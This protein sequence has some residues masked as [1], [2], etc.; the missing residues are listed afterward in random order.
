MVAGTHYIPIALP[1]IL[2]TIFLLAPLLAVAAK[3]QQTS[4]E[5]IKKDLRIR[6]LEAEL[7]ETRG[8][9]E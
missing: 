6:E 8:A 1:S 7:A 4:Q 2:G 9:S 5:I 3:L